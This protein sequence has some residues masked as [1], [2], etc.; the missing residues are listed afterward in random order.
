MKKAY[1]SLQETHCPWDQYK[2]R[3]A[4]VPVVSELRKLGVLRERFHRKL[5]QEVKS[6]DIEIDDLKEKLNMATLVSSSNSSGKKSKSKRRVSCS[7][8]AQELLFHHPR[9]QF[10]REFLVLAKAVWLLHLLAFSLDPPPSH[11]EA[12]NGSEFHLK[13]MENMLKYSIS[14]EIR[15]RMGTGLVVGFPISPGFKLE[16]GSIVK[17]RSIFVSFDD[18]SVGVLSASTL[19]WRCRINPT[20]YLPANP[21]SRVHPLVIAAYP[22]NPNQFT[23]GLNEGAVIALEPLETEGKWGTL[24]P[25]KNGAGPSTS[26]AIY[27][28]RMS[29]WAEHTTTIEQCFERLE[30]LECVRRMRVFGE[31]NWLQYTA[32]EVTEM[33]GHLLKNPVEVD[34]TDTIKNDNKASNQDKA[35]AMIFLRHHLDEEVNVANFHAQL[36][37]KEV[38]TP[39][40]VMVEVEV[41]V[42]EASLKKAKNDIEAN[43]LYED[44]VEPMDLEV[45]NFFIVPEE[46]VNHPVGAVAT[47]EDDDGVPEL[48]AGETFEAAAEEEYQ[49]PPEDTKLFVEIYLYDVDSEGLAQLFQQAD[50][51]EIAE[52]ID[53]RETDRS[54]GF[55]FA[56]M[57]TVEEAEKAV[58]LYNRYVPN[59]LFDV[60]GIICGQFGI[61]F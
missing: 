9:S 44:N 40:V 6:K 3:V 10:Y 56:T 49:E 8:Q 32:N 50:V 20:S 38:L 53:N 16:N 54:R 57:S 58:V 28:Y 47:H 17:A 35:K 31:H 59:S 25:T 33:R 24:P 29:L 51:V 43:F 5:K 18:A 41:V 39:V 12:S 23:L 19:R 27:G 46:H 52:V 22:S 37:M 21:S 11:F 30:S 36:G 60:A 15:G 14:M 1:V 48:M 7:S 2:M 45:S 61:P 13:Y 4:Y 26:G 34:R 42:V 55:R